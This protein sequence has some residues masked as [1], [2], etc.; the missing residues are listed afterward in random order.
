MAQPGDT[1]E[2]LYKQADAALYHVKNHGKNGFAFWHSDL[3][4]DA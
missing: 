1:F 2:M 4:K 3:R